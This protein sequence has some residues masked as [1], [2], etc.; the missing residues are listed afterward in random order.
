MTTKLPIPLRYKDTTVTKEKNK[1]KTD[2]LENQ[3]KNNF[4]KK[5]IQDE[6]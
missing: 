2:I 6:E 3:F 5:K 1:K 4:D